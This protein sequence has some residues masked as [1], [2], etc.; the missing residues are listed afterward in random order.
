MIIFFLKFD[1]VFKQ[2]VKSLRRKITLDSKGKCSE[3]D[4]EC[5][6]KSIYNDI[7]LSLC[8]GIDYALYNLS[9]YL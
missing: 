3:F 8:R 7:K 1:I 5:G 4:F 9:L 6:M 2:I